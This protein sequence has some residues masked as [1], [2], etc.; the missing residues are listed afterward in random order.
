MASLLEREVTRQLCLSV[1]R[2]KTQREDSPPWPRRV[3][4][5]DTNP[6]ASRYCPSASGPAGKSVSSFKASGGCSYGSLRPRRM[7]WFPLP[8]AALAEPQLRVCGA[9]HQAHTCPPT[10]RS[11]HPP[12]GCSRPPGSAWPI[13]FLHQYFVRDR[14]CHVLFSNVSSERKQLFIPRLSQ[15]LCGG[16]DAC[17]RSPVPRPPSETD[18]RPPPPT[19]V[20]SGIPAQGFVVIFRAGWLSR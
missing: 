1:V 13:I 2:V 9:T 7:T 10:S 5:P 20:R 17:H 18:E 11:E 8:P 3:S 19:R 16:E 12:S 15:Q 4:A 6:Q 14:T